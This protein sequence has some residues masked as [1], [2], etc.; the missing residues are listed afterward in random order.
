MHFLFV[1]FAV[2]NFTFHSSL[3]NVSIRNDLKL[4]IVV[5]IDCIGTYW[6]LWNS[7]MHYNKIFQPF[8][9]SKSEVLMEWHETWVYFAIL[10]GHIRFKC[11]GTFTNKIFKVDSGVG[12]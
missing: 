7:F 10:I 4:N 9:I 12:V 1:R 6:L 5:I 2:V 11:E 3:K 8:W